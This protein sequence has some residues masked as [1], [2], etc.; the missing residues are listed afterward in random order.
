MSHTLTARRFLGLNSAFSALNGAALVV[1]G[2]AI[3]PL[4][5]EQPV[6]WAALGLRLVGAG[7][8]G[9]AALLVLLASNRFVSR[10]AVREIVVLDVLWV[11]GSVVAISVFGGVFTTTGVVLVTVVAMVVAF[12][13]IGQFAAAARMQSPASEAQVR[14]QGDT[15]VATVKRAVNAPPETVWNVMTDHPAYADVASNIAKVEVVQGD[16]LGMVRRCHGPKG[17]SWQETCDLFEP[18]QAYGFRIHTEAK[19]YPYPLTELSGRWSVVPHGTGA[20]FDIRIMAKPKGNALARW[21][22]AKL[23]GQQ[24][25]SVLIDLAD[26]WA[27]RM[28]QETNR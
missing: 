16:G 26:G 18:G 11:V 17:E 19:D 23:A 14:L 20:Q 5:F 1:A 3:A 13:A 9:F 10:G 8:I 24:F 12:F 25:K 28:E 4:L 27:L 15:L 22:F 21:M 7:L 6:D 2:G